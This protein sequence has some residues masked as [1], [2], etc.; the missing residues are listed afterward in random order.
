MVL[1]WT[2]PRSTYELLLC[3]ETR[4]FTV[5]RLSVC[6]SAF[7]ESYDKDLYMAHIEALYKG[8]LI[9]LDD[10]SPQ[11]QVSLSRERSSLPVIV[12]RLPVI[13]SNVGYWHTRYE[14]PCACNSHGMLMLI[15]A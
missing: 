4:K 5:L 2:L 10:P 14:L 8:L 11:I 1:S 7:P 13:L 15:W 9:H 6:S 12:T 3:I